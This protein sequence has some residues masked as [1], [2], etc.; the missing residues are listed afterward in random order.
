M[1]AAVAAGAAPWRGA[2]AAVVCAGGELGAACAVG[3]VETVM[4]GDGAFAGGGV[5][6]R[7]GGV[8]RGVGTVGCSALA[9]PPATAL[10]WAVGALRVGAAPGVDCETGAAGCVFG[11]TAAAAAADAAD[12]LEAAGEADAGGVV[13]AVEAGAA[14]AAGDAEIVRLAEAEAAGG[15]E[16]AG[17]AEE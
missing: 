1:E 14:A 3:I 6:A 2:G 13:T 15:A 4:P 9:L 16:P 8:G 12:V 7:V 10:G 5:V 11:A 17:G